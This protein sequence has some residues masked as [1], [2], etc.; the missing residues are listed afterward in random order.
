MAIRSLKTGAFSRSALV[1]NAA[2]NP[3]LFSDTFDT[4]SDV[5]GRTG[6]TVLAGT[7]GYTISGG[8]AKVG[9]IATSTDQTEGWYVTSA[10]TTN[11]TLIAKVNTNFVNE[12]SVARVVLYKDAN[13]Y[14]DLLTYS[15]KPAFSYSPHLWASRQ[16]VAGTTTYV[17]DNTSA[18]GTGNSQTYYCKIARSGN[19]FTFSV[20]S[21]GVSYTSR[22]STTISGWGTTDPLY[23]RFVNENNA[24]AG[25]FYV[26][27]IEVSV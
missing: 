3:I 8:T 5:Y 26:D 21:D 20:S 22:G 12:G 7:T 17:T 27:S 23:V 18:V 25:N 19:T 24:N 16:T 14:V 13:N 2:Y 4:G 10:F 1:G 9:D 15:G 6:Y 11:F